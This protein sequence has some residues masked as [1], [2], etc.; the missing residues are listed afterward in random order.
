VTGREIPQVEAGRRA[1]DPAALVAGAQRAAAELG[2]RPRRSDLDTM[3]ADAWDFARSCA[4]STATSGG[5]NPRRRSL[6]RTETSETREQTVNAVEPIAAE[7]THLFE[8]VY[9]AAPA[10]LWAAPGRVNVIGEHTDYNEGFVLPMAIDRYTV[11]AAGPRSDGQL[12]VVSAAGD[13]RVIDIAL[14]A[15]SPACRTVGPRIRRA[16]P[17]RCSARAC[18]PRTSPARTW[19]SPRRCRWA[20]ACRPRRRWSARPAWRWPGSPPPS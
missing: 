1:G 8:S 17:G 11:V 19:R 6:T 5:E 20:R 4:P 10:G 7:A 2:W 14:D 16:S 13:R 12:R 9:G 18:C 3:I 15:L